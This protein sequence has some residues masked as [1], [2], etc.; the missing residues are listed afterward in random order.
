VLR[1]NTNEGSFGGLTDDHYYYLA[2][3]WQLLHGDLPD[4]DF[5]DI[6]APLTYV[7][8]WIAQLVLGRGTWSEVVLSVT[9]LSL[10]AA[11]TTLIATR[12][13]GSLL[14]GFL[15]GLFEILLQPR[16][17]NYP[18]LLVYAAAVPAVW[19]LM[20]RQTW[21]TRIV[22]A[23]V[24]VMALLLRHDHGVFVGLLCVVAIGVSVPSRLWLP[25]WLRYIA[26]V[27]L[28][29]SPYL[30]YLQL[31]GGVVT[32]FVTANSWAARDRDRAPLVYPTFRLSAEQQ[33]VE[34]GDVADGF[35]VL[36]TNATPWVFYVFVT[37]PFVALVL[38]SL[39]RDVWRPDWP[40]AR[41]KLLVVA[42]L[43]IVL[44]AGFLRGALAARLADVAVPQALLIAWMV[45]AA[46][47]WLR[48]NLADDTAPRTR[49]AGLAGAAVVLGVLAVTVQMIAVTAA[50]TVSQSGLTE[51]P[52]AIV[53]RALAST[54]R[55]RDGW[56]L[57]AR[58]DA[59]VTG[60][61]ALVRYLA[62]C[63]R[64]EHRVLVSPYLP[65]VA[66]LA[67]RAFAGGHTDLRSGFFNARADQELTVARL[68]R[69]VPPVLIVPPSGAEY[70]GLADDMP[71]VAQYID[72]AYAPIVDR[73]LGSMAVGIRIR[74]DEPAVSQY[75]P[76]D[77]PCL[78]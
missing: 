76:L 54:T 68:R 41:E 17:Y 19:T 38:L 53:G 27:G 70:D 8:S 50:S 21:T 11:L 44:N 75:D 31:N 30:A 74:R 28:F 5:V 62:A 57:A 67:D 18:K 47:Q 72:A 51:G 20:D 29:V 4:R 43:A 33:A 61:L 65:Q 9:A 23:I 40:R 60:P 42:L 12:V 55:L 77:L 25:E 2:R 22:A 3:G 66:A 24:T 69:D 48:D 59:D 35:D 10:A 78:R 14:L 45:A 26:L 58:L 34:S 32:H 16:L 37:V 56:P 64:E 49:A 46:L 73:D 71:L 6:G 7:I 63:T 1:Y 52:R 13:T 15:A 39:R 36:R